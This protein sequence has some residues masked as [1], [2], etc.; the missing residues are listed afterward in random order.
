VPAAS[1]AAS[2][3]DAGGEPVR[4]R[5]RR[6]PLAGNAGIGVLIIV[7]LAALAAPNV[8][9]RNPLAQSL[10]DRL[11][12]PGARGPHGEVFWLGTDGLGRD[13]L[14]RLIYGAR[15]SL[16]VAS[17]A[18][19]CSGAL[20]VFLGL[21]A[22][23]YR[24]LVGAV[25]MRFVDLVL[26]IP[27]LLLAIAVVAALG[28]GLEHTVLVLG[29]TR[30]PRY[31]RVA[32][33]QTLAGRSREFVEAARALGGTDL[34]VMLRHVLPE[35]LPSVIVVGT[36][37][38]GL[39]IVYEAAL[40]FLGLGVQPPT[41]SWGNMLADGRAYLETGWWLATFPGLAIMVT[42]LGANLLGD[43]VRDRL[44]PRVL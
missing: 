8:A 4:R 14:S 5:R 11:M 32:F 36:L 42:V 6:L 28:P 40:S 37:E 43:A 23:Y 39:M 16:A 27:F 34:R 30:W 10:A 26:S 15:A 18:V 25:L 17:L 31:A 12:S 24:G 2:P 9:P 35:V 29:L 1:A 21:T 41:P 38:I 3:F 19:A 22:G 20:G 44:D 7:A 33:A 13:V